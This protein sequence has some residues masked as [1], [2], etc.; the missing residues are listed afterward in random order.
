[1]CS[2]SLSRPPTT[3]CSSLGFYHI[4]FTFPSHF[5]FHVVR[6]SELFRVSKLIGLGHGS[7]KTDRHQEPRCTKNPGWLRHWTPELSPTSS[8]GNPTPPT[9]DLDRDSSSVLSS[10][11]HCSFLSSRGKIFRV[12]HR[13]CAHTSIASTSRPRKIR[14]KAPPTRRD[15][16]DSA[17]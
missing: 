7:I 6:N 2:L 4:S 8:R 3:C 16:E 9:F 17:L 11:F 12:W 10:P 1:M 15:V 5:S 13:M 14:W